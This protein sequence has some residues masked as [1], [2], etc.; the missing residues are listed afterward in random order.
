MTTTQ[1]GNPLCCIIHDIHS[2]TVYHHPYHPTTHAD[3]ISLLC[4]CCH[5]THLHDTR[6]L[7]RLAFIHQKSNTFWLL[8]RTRPAVIIEG[9]KTLP[10]FLC[11]CPFGRKTK[12]AC[13]HAI[14]YSLKEG[15]I[16]IPL[17]FSIERIGVAAKRGAPKKA[18][19]GQALVRDP[20]D[21]THSFVQHAPA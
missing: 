17:E 16:S 12:N 3:T 18:T 6:L 13:K 14:G 1:K 2:F 11:K 15:S 10:S 7:H 19:P 4:I 5:L 9:D 20:V 8:K 21:I